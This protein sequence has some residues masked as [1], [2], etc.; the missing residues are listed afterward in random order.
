[1]KGF[2]CILNGMLQKSTHSK[3]NTDS[4]W[5]PEVVLVW[6]GELSN[7]TDLCAVSAVETKPV[8]SSINNTSEFFCWYSL[9]PWRGAE[10]SCISG[11][12]D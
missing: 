7:V 8:D 5:V 10:V 9:L 11:V 4:G 1:M 2:V 6:W 3:R 12:G